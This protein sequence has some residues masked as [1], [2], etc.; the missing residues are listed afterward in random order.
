VFP[1]WLFGV[2]LIFCG[3]GQAE[4]TAGVVHDACSHLLVLPA[5]DSRNAE[6]E[7]VG[8]GISFWHD[9]GVT[10]PRLE[11]TSAGPTVP[12]HF[13]VAPEAFR[14]VYEPSTGEVFVNRR[15]ED[16][17]ERSVTVAHEL[18]HALGLPHVPPSERPSMMNPGNLTVLPTNEDVEALARLWG[19]CLDV[20]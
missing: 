11:Q 18:G 5:E 13:E 16:S 9:V 14:G 10:A 20:P 6:R 19:D 12:V 4:T 17:F 1:R 2:A 15:L 7:G 3:C 8:R